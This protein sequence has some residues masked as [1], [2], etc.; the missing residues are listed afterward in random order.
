MAISDQQ[1][2]TAALDP[3]RSF[4]VQ[5]PAGSGKTELLTQ[6][7]LRLLAEVEAPEQ[8]L[9][10]TFTR[11]AAAEMRERI[12]KA[13][14][15]AACAP[16]EAAHKR[17]TWELARAVRT[18]DAARDWRLLQHPAR[19]RIQ[20][21]DALNAS[22]ARRL[23]V[24]AGAGAAIEPTDDPWPLYEAACARLIDRLGEGSD[25]CARLEHL[26]VHLANRVDRIVVLLSELLA[27]RD[28]W[29]HPVVRA[30][31]SAE[32][33]ASLEGALRAVV[34]RHLGALCERL[35]DQRRRE[36]LELSQYAAANLLANGAGARRGALEACLD[37][38]A[39]SSEGASLQAWRGAASLLFT[40]KNELYASVN[41]KQGFPPTNPQLK[42][43]MLSMLKAFGGDKA[44]CEQL[45]ELRTLPDPVYAQEQWRMLEALLE[46]LPAAVAELQLVFQAQ[47]RADYIEVA[48]RA[49][50]ALG[51]AEE[52]T[53]LALAFDYRIQHILV[54]EFQDTSF[55]QLD[56]LER[57][58]AGWTE[59]EGRTLF[60][61]GDPMQSIY[62]FRQAEV[63]LFL[64][65]QRHGLRNL[66]LTPLTLSANFRSDPALVEWVNAAFPAVLAPRNDPEQGAVSYSPSVPARSAAGGGVQVHPL[67]NADAAAEAALVRKLVVERLQRDPAG[68][69]AVLAAARAHIDA[70]ARELSLA[71]I[72]FQAV[73][74]E[75]LRDRPIV[76]DLMALTRALVHLAD[77]TAWLA[78]LRAPWCG[79]TLA[80][81][82]AIADAQENATIIDGLGRALQ[83]RRLSEQDHERA[84]RTYS[85]LTAALA[86]R[87]RH[88]LRLWIERAWNALG[89]PATAARQTDLNDAD[90]YFTRLQAI[91]VVG[92]L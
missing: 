31:Q 19:L 45:L 54:D 51:P 25:V 23:P 79:L 46:L 62:R 74:I 16:P 22:L 4:I 41:V 84:S 33:R 15:G 17:I 27:K 53:D 6:R 49:L 70:L 66:A 80:D 77:R 56:L 89:G 67:V 88:P 11:K 48:L 82:H 3:Q 38:D 34:E 26:I 90:A 10:I 73:D 47:G 43:R 81:L 5:A 2:R 13:L 29:L 72:A 44:L 68:S 24:L 32:L 40:Q 21:I 14:A 92:D 50:Q 30:R 39:L 1:T 60:C 71:G 61:V 8:I 75:R 78:V 91:E 52:P 59:G 85:V 20:T 37:C 42:G 87:G 12:L 9:A 86:E 69:I 36:L 28:Q 55:A 57:L 35:G 65:L 7:C 58:T 64:N 18:V 76:Q 83:S 63:G